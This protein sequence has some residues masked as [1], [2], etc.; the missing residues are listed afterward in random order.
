MLTLQSDLIIFMFMPYFVIVVETQCIILLNQILPTYGGTY[1]ILNLEMVT[2][3]QIFS[4]QLFPFW[5]GSE[6]IKT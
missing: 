3:E 1:G 4:I 6:L 5:A 2:W